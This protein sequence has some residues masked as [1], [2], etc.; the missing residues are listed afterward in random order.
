M[1]NN[2]TEY[3]CTLDAIK[4]FDFVGLFKDIDTERGKRSAQLEFLIENQLDLRLLPK[5]AINLVCQNSDAKTSLECM[6][7]QQ[8]MQIYDLRINKDDFFGKNS[9]IFINHDC[10]QDHISVMIDGKTHRTGGMFIVQ[11]KSDHNE[12]NIDLACNG[13][14]CATFYYDRITTVY[15]K[16]KR[17][18]VFVGKRAYGVYYKYEQ[19]LWLI[20][21][22]HDQSDFD[23]SHIERHREFIPYD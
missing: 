12:E 14:I 8:P 6:L 13:N 5:D 19:Q 16:E 18:D 2:R 22:N 17:L 7:T 11:I 9:R 10:D 1:S 23:Y 21:T 3:D 20:Y 15:G 4:R